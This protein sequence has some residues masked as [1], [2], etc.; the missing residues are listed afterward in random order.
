MEYRQILGLLSVLLT[1]T[2]YSIYFQGIF[3]GKIKPHAFSWLVWFIITVVSFFIQ[4]ENGA[5]PGAWITGLTSFFCLLITIIGL[6]KG[7]NEIRAVDWY[8]ILLA[9]I[10]IF[11]WRMIQEPVLSIFLV[12]TA[13]FFGFI[14]TIR[15]TY[16]NPYTE[17]PT[18]Y[19]IN[20]VRFSFSFFALDKISFLTAAYTLYVIL[21]NLLFIIMIVLRRKRVHL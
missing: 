6:L 3:T 14:P 8:S 9:F 1:L 20:L 4:M 17:I 13:D 21:A 7:K 10:A 19:A 18:T 12:I 11:F 5:G 15:K 16:I 2:V